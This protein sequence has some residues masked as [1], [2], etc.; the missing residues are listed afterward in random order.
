[1]ASYI[2]KEDKELLKI[3]PPEPSTVVNIERDFVVKNTGT[4]TL[5]SVSGSGTHDLLYGA[6]RL[7]PGSTGKS[8][9]YLAATT[10]P[11]NYYAVQADYITGST[12]IT[13]QVGVTA[14]VPD[15]VDIDDLNILEIGSSKTD[16]MFVFK[17]ETETSYIFI[18][19]E[20]VG[21]VNTALSVRWD[22]LGM[23]DVSLPKNLEVRSVNMDPLSTS[24]STYERRGLT[25][26]K[27]IDGKYIRFTAYTKGIGM[28]G[29]PPYL[30]IKG[31]LK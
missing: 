3:N 1:M 23:M 16:T 8:V 31:E 9:I 24:F 15:S 18:N 21:A 11:G 26:E 20:N 2:K 25:I 6:L 29:Q 17:A 12:A 19:I 10:T 4:N 28:Y 14:S 30:Q 13:S 27:D 22:G 7:F 5:Q